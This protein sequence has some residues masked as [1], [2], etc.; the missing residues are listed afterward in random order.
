MTVSRHE[1]TALETL[2]ERGGCILT[3]QVPDKNHPGV[4][5]VE[6]GLA[7]YR[8]LARLGLVYFTEEEP[9]MLDGEPFTF[10]NEIYITDE[11]R[12]VVEC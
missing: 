7:V 5:G 6:P 8:R 9:I 11:G 3:T 12:K 4:F 1:R 10:T 2:I